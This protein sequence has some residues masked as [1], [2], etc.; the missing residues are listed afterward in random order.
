MAVAQLA[1]QRNYLKKNLHSDGILRSSSYWN[2]GIPFDNM[3]VVKHPQD[4]SDN[5]PETTGFPPDTALMVEIQ[6]MQFKM[7]AILDKQHL[8]FELTLAN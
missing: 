1:Y 2:D 8:R 4:A 6:S 5:T 3:V 7:K